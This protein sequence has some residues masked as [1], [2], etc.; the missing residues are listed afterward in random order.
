MEGLGRAILDLKDHGVYNGLSF[1]NGITL[2][3][4]L[5]V[6]DIVLVFDGS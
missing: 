6:D 4:V 2:T 3:H 5:F 1:G